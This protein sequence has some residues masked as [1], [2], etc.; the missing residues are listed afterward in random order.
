[1]S[2]YRAN[3]VAVL[4]AF[5]LPATVLAANINGRGASLKLPA[6][7]LSSGGAQTVGAGGRLLSAGTPGSGVVS[8][9]ASEARLIIEPLYAAPG[10][11]GGGAPIAD[12]TVDRL[13]GTAPLEVQFTD[14]S[15]GGWYEILAWTWDFGDG[16]PYSSEQNPQHTYEET[17]TYWVTL[18]IL[19]PG[20]TAT[21]TRDEYIT[22]E[23]PVP[24][25]GWAGLLLLAVVLTGSGIFWARRRTT[26]AAG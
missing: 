4:A 15:S 21:T 26:M 10:G 9:S 7:E 17:G 25:A 16:S 13:A 20:G 11:P 12:F 8:L 1:M 18:T 3:F 5:L 23:Q 24:V 2:R 22:V 14:L 19:T 6:A